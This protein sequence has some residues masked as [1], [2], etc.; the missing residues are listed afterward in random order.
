[1]IRDD[2]NCAT[3]SDTEKRQEEAGPH[4]GEAGGQDEEGGQ[5]QQQQQDDR[6][7]KQRCSRTSPL[8][9]L[10]AVVWEHSWCIIWYNH[11]ERVNRSKRITVK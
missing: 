6:Q 10:T 1:M 5:Q 7:Q 4:H 3:F 9:C 8:V 11:S 2:I